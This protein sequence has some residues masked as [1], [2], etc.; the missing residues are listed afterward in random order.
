VLCKGCGTCVSVC[1]SGS[2][3]QNFFEDEEIYAEI[4]GVLAY[5]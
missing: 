4:G 1:P 3:R 2:A 5:V